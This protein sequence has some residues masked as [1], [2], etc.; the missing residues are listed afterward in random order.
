M[1]F[2]YLILREYTSKPS[3]SEGLMD[4]CSKRPPEQPDMTCTHAVMFRPGLSY[5]IPLKMSEKYWQTG[6]ETCP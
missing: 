5:L 4:A 1:C 3:I 2:L 6:S